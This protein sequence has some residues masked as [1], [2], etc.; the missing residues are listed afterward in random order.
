MGRLLGAVGLVALLT[1]CVAPRPLG[2]VQAR[3]GRL[4]AALHGGKLVFKDD[5][6]RKTLGDAWEPHAQTWG[7]VNGRLQVKMAHNQGCW[8]RH[9]LPEKFRVEFDAT[10]LSAT[11]DLKFEIVAAERK[12]ETGYICI[13]G[14][15]HNSLDV[16]ARLDEHGRDRLTSTKQLVEPNRTYHFAVLRTD[17]T[18]QW[19]LD[20]QLFLQYED[21]EPLRGKWFGFNDWEAPVAFDNLAVYDLNAR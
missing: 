19:F 15:W 14:G 9:P 13:F 10:A 1:G 11:G 17:G 5:F 3:S 2:A 7:I 6:N 16:I 20:G 8:L 18:L 12:H 4:G 21:R